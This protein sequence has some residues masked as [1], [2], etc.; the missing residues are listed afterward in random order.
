[1]KLIPSFNTI[2]GSVDSIVIDND[3]RHLNW[4]A[5]KTGF[6]TPFGTF[7]TDTITKSDNGLTVIYEYYLDDITLK[8]ERRTI[9]DNY[10][11]TYTFTNKDEKKDITV[12]TDKMGIY[13]PFNDSYDIAEVSLNRRCNAHIWCGGNCTYIYGLR[14]NGED[15]NVGLV[16]TKGYIDSYGVER[17]NNSNDRGDFIFYLN[18]FT[19]EPKQSYV[20]EWE[21]FA[22]TDI[23]NFFD[24][25]G[26]YE[27]FINLQSKR[28]SCGLGETFTLT[29]DRFID[30]AI[31]DDE[32]I[33]AANTKVGAKI[34]MSYKTIGEKLLSLTY[35]KYKTYAW[36]N[37]YDDIMSVIDRRINFIIDKQQILDIDSKYYG[38][39]ALFDNEENE[40]FILPGRLSNK[41]AARERVGMTCL[42]ISRLLKGVN[43]IDFKNK[44]NDSMLLSVDFIGKQIVK[45]DGTV[46]DDA[47]Y[48]K[49]IAGMHRKYNYAWYANM[50]TMLYEL[51]LEIKYMNTAMKI[52]EKFYAIGGNECYA[53]GLPIMRLVALTERDNLHDIG[54]RAKELFLS[55]GDAILNNGNNIP[56]HEVKFEQSIL[57]PA[58]NILLSCYNISGDVKYL[59][60][61]EK[62]VK[63]L[64]AM[65][66]F[67]PDFH[68]RDISIRHWDGYWFGKSKMYGDTFPHYWSCLTAEV[69]VLYANVSSNNTY[70]ERADNIL[71]NNLCLF[72]EEGKG[73]A[74]F[75]YPK[76]VN[77]RKGH[78]YDAYAND[79]DWAL[80]YTLEYSSE[81]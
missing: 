38:A 68:M 11:E 23:H 22:F 54:T 29:A 50:Y 8:V 72:D 48:K 15:N 14:M 20:V 24:K 52:L 81:I 10:R 49:N 3:N 57:A 18:E 12:K 74:A 45:E 32:D 7:Y 6:G 53:I 62:F 59:E 60:A 55:H 65:N 16:L 80:Y 2:S 40:P 26:D 36:F 56:S 69:F 5:G 31:L 34:L 51:T 4:V 9:G 63:Y 1:M 61:S 41:N 37:V 47:G 19:L 66:G 64:I 77:G 71:R 75:I 39:Y 17:K 78:F 76:F 70:I 44:I 73:S 30:S 67:Q 33:H 27:T 35:G 43:N 21:M 25:A 58:A 28:F 42:M 13:V 79:Q 46:S